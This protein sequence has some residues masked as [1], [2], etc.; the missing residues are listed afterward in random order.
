MY[1]HLFET[2]FSR[3]LGLCP[4]VEFLDHEVILFL[5]F[6]GTTVV[7]S[8]CSILR[9]QQQRTGGL[10]PHILTSACYFIF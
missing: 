9:A 2:P 10:V 7:H 3:H 1:T 5:I 8:S 6:W 4:E